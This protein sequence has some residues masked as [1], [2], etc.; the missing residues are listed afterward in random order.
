MSPN[1][2]NKDLPDSEGDVATTEGAPS[3]PSRR[4]DENLPDSEGDAS[5]AQTGREASPPSRVQAVSIRWEAPLPP[6]ALLEQYDQ[7]VPGLAREIAEQAKVEA[8]HLREHENN[9]L[10]AS[11]QYRAR[12]RW[13]AFIAMMAVIGLAAFALQMDAR[14]VAGIAVSIAVGTA[15]V[16]VLEPLRKRKDKDDKD[17][18]D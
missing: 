5:A 9:M 3:R 4:G 7:I 1:G 2:D 12:G 8:G 18:E 17:R 6:P 11:I 14:W 13:M 10:K 15:S 16:F